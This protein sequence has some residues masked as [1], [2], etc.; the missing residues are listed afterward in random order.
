MNQAHLLANPM[1]Q[2]IFCAGTQSA[3]RARRAVFA[4]FLRQTADDKMEEQTDE[5]KGGMKLAAHA[6]C[7]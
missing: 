3:N 5:T 6:L 1:R 7:A 2:S 4:S